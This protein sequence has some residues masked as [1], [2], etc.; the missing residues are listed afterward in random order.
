MGRGEGRNRPKSVPPIF[1]LPREG[2]QRGEVGA[3][4][5]VPHKKYVRGSGEREERRGRR[6]EGRGTGQ[7]KVAIPTTSTAHFLNSYYTL[8]ISYCTICVKTHLF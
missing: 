4:K 1:S 2:E 8:A 7:V 6:G 5:S 3:G